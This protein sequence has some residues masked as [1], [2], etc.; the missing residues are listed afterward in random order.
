MVRLR[1]SSVDHGKVSL[2]GS[3]AARSSISQRSCG[4]RTSGGATTLGINSEQLEYLKKLATTSTEISG[5][6]YNYQKVRLQ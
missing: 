6:Q 4:K 2:L 3:P 5:S 1:R